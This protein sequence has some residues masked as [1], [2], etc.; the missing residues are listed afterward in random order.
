VVFDLDGTLVDSAAD[1]ASSASALAVELGG[2]PL[3]RG[4]V[5]GM[6]GEGAPVLV[7]RVLTAAALDPET[8]GALGRFLALYDARLLDTTRLYPGIR[9]AL[10]Q[11]DP[12]LTL[13]VL[14]NKPRRPAE[15][16]L[17]GLGVRQLFL[18]VVGGDGP[19]PRKP[20]PAGLRSLRMHAGAGPMALV[21][22]SP[23]DAETARRGGVPF[24]L[25]GYGFGAA[26]FAAAPT[27][28][29]AASPADLPRVIRAALASAAPPTA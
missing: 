27:A 7:R 6:V 9:R 20:D 19:L 22:D 10:D 13:I 11:L 28:F 14:T 8:P 18:E 15:R 3:A 16:V 26:A 5:V 2:R 17:D 4:E 23:V 12:L 21:G 24:V 25:A 1:L 29:V